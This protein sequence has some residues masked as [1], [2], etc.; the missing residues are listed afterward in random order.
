M[1]LKKFREMQQLTQAQVGII[2]QI[3]QVQYNRYE[4]EQREIPLHHLIA[5]AD[6]YG[7]TLDELVGRTSKKNPQSAEADR[8]LD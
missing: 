5:L 6:L 4:T 8:G 3:H 1:E 7:C 2:L